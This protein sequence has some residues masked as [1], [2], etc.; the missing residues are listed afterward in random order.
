MGEPQN[1]KAVAH[2]VTAPPQAIP[3]PQQSRGVP[4]TQKYADGLYYLIG[5]QF[6]TA[7][8]AKAFANGLAAFCDRDGKRLFLKRAVAINRDGIGNCS[9]VN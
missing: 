2:L 6:R 8:E 5:L 9:G 3:A 7:A 1:L 4:I